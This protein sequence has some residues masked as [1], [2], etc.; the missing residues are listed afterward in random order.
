MVLIASF[1]S[2]E[3]ANERPSYHHFPRAIFERFFVAGIWR[4]IT[5]IILPRQPA[6][7]ETKPVPCRSSSFGS[8]RKVSLSCLFSFRPWVKDRILWPVISQ[9]GLSLLLS[10][11][12]P[13][14]RN[15]TT[16]WTNK[17]NEIHPVIMPSPMHAWLFWSLTSG[18]CL[19][20]TAMVGPPT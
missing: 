11:H 16:K 5:I 19:A 1:R 10:S 6:S 4:T 3:R 20:M 13:P 18:A 2:V 9:P 15:P 14:V 12:S 7:Q 8:K 17:Q